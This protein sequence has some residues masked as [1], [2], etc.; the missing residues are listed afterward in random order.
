MEARDA[1]IKPGEEAQWCIF[2][3]IIS[4]IHG[5]NLSNAPE[6]PGAGNERR[7]QAHYLNRAIGQLTGDTENATAIQCP[8]AYFL[9]DGIYIPNE[10]TP[11]QWTQANLKMALHWLKITAL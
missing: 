11:L 4:C 2:D 7:L 9:E 10:H 8:E 1:H 6:D 3:P 5:L